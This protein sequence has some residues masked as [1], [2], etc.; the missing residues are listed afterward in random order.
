MSNSVVIDTNLIFSALIPNNSKIRDILIE[1]KLTIYAPNFII[2]EI[3]THK[4]KIIKYSKLSETEFYKYFS[5]ITEH[6]KFVPIDF[7]NFESKQKAYY[8]CKDVDIKDT[9]FIALAIDLDI[10]FWTGD[11]KLINGLIAKGYTNFYNI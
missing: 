4:E 6:I 11:K 10:P 2:T 5:G 9:P 3:F 7:I 8:L 1:S